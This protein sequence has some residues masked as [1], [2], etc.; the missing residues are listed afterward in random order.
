MSNNKD[1]KSLNTKEWIGISV[2]VALICYLF[3]SNYLLSIFNPSQIM[4]TPESTS[5]GISIQDTTVGS[6]VVAEVGDVVVANYTGR[7]TDGTVFDSSEGKQPISFTLGAG[8]VIQGWDQGLVGMKEGGKRKLTIS[9]AF[10][11]GSRQV[12]PI[13]PNST[14]VFDV[15]LVK[16]VKH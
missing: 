2:A 9:P 12:G 1:M 4:E 11:Y 5:N 16:V 6:G 3:F 15:E 8:Q 10:A 13:P 14:L 7:L